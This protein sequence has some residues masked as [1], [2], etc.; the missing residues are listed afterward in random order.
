MCIQNTLI[1][2]SDVWRF[3]CSPLLS[4]Q[5]NMTADKSKIRFDLCVII[6]F[7]LRKTYK[8][9]QPHF[10][11][12]HSL[13]L[14]HTI[15]LQKRHAGTARSLD[16]RY[17]LQ[18]QRLDNGAHQN[19]EDFPR[20]M[21]CVRLNGNQMFGDI[22]CV[23]SR[24][25]PNRYKIPYEISRPLTTY[26]CSTHA[27]TLMLACKLLYSLLLLVVHIPLYSRLLEEM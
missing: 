27:C 13:V 18:P 1:R 15:I 16:W 26:A 10:H 5:A 14:Y 24:E 23:V 9:A 12:P 6:T 19:W 2:S 4:N 11:L 8:F 3:N 21:G 17:T 22:L 20:M 25:C 7:D